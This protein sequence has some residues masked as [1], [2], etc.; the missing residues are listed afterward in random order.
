MKPCRF[1]IDQAH[2]A[3]GPEST[4]MDTTQIKS[5]RLASLYLTESVSCATLSRHWRMRTALQ[6]VEGKQTGRF[7]RITGRE[8]PFFVCT[9]TRHMHL[10]MRTTIVPGAASPKSASPL[11]RREVG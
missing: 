9:G 1:L 7:P 3:R 2:E 4:D 8:A 10:P 6:R 5:S 11:R